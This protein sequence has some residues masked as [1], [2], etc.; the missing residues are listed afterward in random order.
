[1][2]GTANLTPG[3]T[4]SSQNFTYNFT[5]SLS[6]CQSSTSGAPATGTTTAGVQLPETVTLTNTSTGGTSTGTVQYQE[7]VP[8]GSGGCGSSTTSGSALTTWADGTHTVSSYST[9][10]AA[11]AVVLQGSVAPSLTLTLVSSSVPAGFTAPA[12][13]TIS[14]NRMAVGD[15]VFAPLTFSPADQSQDCV[16]TPVTSASING[17]VTIGSA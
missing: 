13:F 7:P 2:Q 3:L 5:G 6:S 8:T 9:S 12:T 10:G 1:M 4:S 15:T 14:T 17:L 16:T 11:A